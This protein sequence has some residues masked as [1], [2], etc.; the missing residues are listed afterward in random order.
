MK[1]PEATFRV[2]CGTDGCCGCV[3]MTY[4][5]DEQAFRAACNECG[6]LVGWAKDDWKNKADRARLGRDA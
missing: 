3:V 5:P 1:T 2:E 4:I 6:K